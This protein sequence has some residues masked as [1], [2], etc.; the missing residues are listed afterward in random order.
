MSFFAGVLAFFQGLGSAVQLA[1]KVVDGVKSL[2]QFI[3]RNRNEAWF[4]ESTR[5][6]GA[7]ESAKTQEESER[8][9]KDYLRLI[10]RLGR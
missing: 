6:F 1:L 7:I 2:A 9:F 4:Q 8:A 3:E 10:G 5:V